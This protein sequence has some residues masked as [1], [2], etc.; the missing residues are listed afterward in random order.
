[1]AEERKRRSILLEATFIAHG[2]LVLQLLEATKKG[3]MD[4]LGV[5]GRYPACEMRRVLH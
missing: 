3:L 1:V 2:L 5:R 4:F